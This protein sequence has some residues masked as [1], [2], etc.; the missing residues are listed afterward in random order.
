M[1]CFHLL[2]EHNKVACNF[3][4]FYVSKL[5]NVYKEKKRNFELGLQCLV[6]HVMGHF[7]SS[8]GWI[9]TF[10]CR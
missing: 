5:Q 2:Q 6:K 4:G 3:C 7:T 10:R 9:E 8:D 1:C